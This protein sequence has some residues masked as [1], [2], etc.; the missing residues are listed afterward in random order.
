MRTPSAHRARGG[1]ALGAALC[2]AVLAALLLGA[3][4]AAGFQVGI[5]EDGYVT[6]DTAVRDQLFDKTAKVNASIVRINV[7]WSRVARS[8]PA[9]PADPADPAYFWRSVDAAVQAANQRGLEVLLT[10]NRAPTYAEGP[11]RPADVNPGTWRP[12]PGALA[13]FAT[14]IASR[15]SGGFAGLPRVRDY[16]VWN[17]PNIL[18]HLNPQRDGS[19]LVSPTLFRNMVNAF[20]GAV[21]AVHRDNLVV[22][23]G[24]APYGDDS[25]N[26]RI[27]PLAFLRA[28]FCLPANLKGPATCDQQTHFDVLAHNPINTVASPTSHAAN[29]DDVPTAD[30]GRVRKVLRAAEKA[31][32]AP[33]G[34]HP[35]WATEIWWGTNPPNVQ[36]GIPLDR[37]AR[38]IEQAFYVLWK[39]GASVVLNFEIRDQAYDPASPLASLQS[40]LFFNDFTAK[41]SATA[42]AFPFVTQRKGKQKVLAWGIAPKSGKLKIQRRVKKHWRA[43]DK[44]KAKSGRVFT[45]KL[46]LKGKA[47]LRAQMKGKKSFVWKQAR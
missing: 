22:T 34:P 20:Y 3:G 29:H 36:F 8:Q 16:Q 44:L 45:A 15:Y 12:D 19:Q 47:E 27:R 7:D 28:M 13:A 5:Q 31:G 26:A 30:F 2:V 37:Q 41:P 14:A 24:T 10:I 46:R 33:G 6:G 1:A 32:T 40:G 4:S 39:A 17:E 23:G 11:G 42:F 21:K 38:Y 25:G 9:N 43:I 35:L 18:Q